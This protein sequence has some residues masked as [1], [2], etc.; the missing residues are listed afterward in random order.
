MTGISLEF[1]DIIPHSTVLYKCCEHC[2][3]QEPDFQLNFFHFHAICCKKLP[4]NRLAHPTGATASP[5]G[6]P[7][8]TPGKVE[9]DMCRV[10]HHSDAECHRYSTLDVEHQGCQSLKLAIKRLSFAP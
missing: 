7:G 6:N 1:M 3:I 10:E 9:S 8:S 2:W 5:K 4:N